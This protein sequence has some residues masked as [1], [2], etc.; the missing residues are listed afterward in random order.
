MVWLLAPGKESR[1]RERDRERAEAAA[2]SPFVSDSLGA[3]IMWG[4]RRERDG[5]AKEWGER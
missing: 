4:G 1:E 3:G 2:S 5:G